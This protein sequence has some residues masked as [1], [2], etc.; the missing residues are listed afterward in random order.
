MKQNKQ[1]QIIFFFPD[2][3]IGGVEKNFFIISKYLSK[4]FKYTYLVNGNNIG[5]KLD[6]N[7]KLIKISKFWF[8]FNRRLSFIICSIKLL[9]ISIKVK[10]SIIF[11]F[12]GNFYA[13]LVAILLKKK[14]IIRSNLSPHGWQSSHFKIKFF[15]FLLSKA[16]VVIVN[17]V[18]FQREMK[19]KFDINASTIF[20]PVD[21]NELKKLSSYKKRINFYKK[22][23]IN[24]IN[25]GRLVDQKNQIEILKA[26]VKLNDSVKNY[27]LL[28]IGYG[29]D[30]LYLKNFI[31]Q[32]KLKKYVKI[33]FVK[34]PLKYINM[35]DVF[36]LSSKYEGLP[37]TLLEA[38]HL[39][40]YIISSNCKTGPNEI[41]K[42]YKNGELYNSGNINELYLKLKKLNKKKLSN[43]KINS[44]KNLTSF[45]HKINLEKYLKTILQLF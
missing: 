5:N 27:R 10:N 40:K 13:I 20:N 28:I 1:N 36:I 37:N 26:F 9:Y 32:N 12:Q 24:L 42:K 6:K 19:K 38:A 21:I 33:I 44:L 25:V 11:S 30:E 31:R 17:S 45:G 23:T 8:N 16:N 4:F 7:I 43:Q 34:N 15:K 41:I 2:I 39:N 29:P 18:E 22:N 3:Q 35:S 14:I